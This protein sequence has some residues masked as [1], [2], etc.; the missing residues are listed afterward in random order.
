[1][2]MLYGLF[3]RHMRR[4]QSGQALIIM[5][6]GFVGLLGFLGLVTDVSLLLVR[7][8]QLIRAVDSAAINAANQ[9][10]SDRSF[11][12]VGL[13]ARMMIEMHGFESEEILVQTCESLGGAGNT[14]DALC[15]EAN[16]YRKLVRVGARVD[17]PTVFLRVLGIP[18]IEISAVSTSETAVL[19]VV[20]VMDVSESMLLDTTYAD[21]ASIGYG[22]VYVPPVL[23]DQDGNESANIGIFEKETLRASFETRVSNGMFPNAHNDTAG[24]LDDRLQFWGADVLGGVYNYNMVYPDQVNDRL[25]YPDDGGTSSTPETDQSNLQYRVRSFNYPGTTNQAAPREA[26]RVR[27][28]PYSVRRLVEP[29]IRSISGY[30]ALWEGRSLANTEAKWGGFIPTYDFYGCCNDPT[31]GGRF[32]YQDGGPLSG[33]WVNSANNAGDNDFSDLICQ[34]FKAARDA[35]RAFL[36]TLDFERGDRVALVT[37]DRGA[38]L[39]DPDGSQGTTDLAALGSCPRDPDPVSGRSNMNHMMASFCRASATL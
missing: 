26:C 32:N 14:T 35:T 22:R 9:M 37:F 18:D 8:N 11:G 17:S 4:S 36:Q 1:M 15:N 38:F 31:A 24:L 3:P 28:W 23:E 6:L 10:R 27:F 29:H 20:M 25:Y 39:V 21:W 30:S 13:A 16:R 5:T 34:P 7:Q 2:R 33:S 19:D 12:Q